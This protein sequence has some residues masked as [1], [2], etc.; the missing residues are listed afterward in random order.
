LGSIGIGLVWGWLIGNFDGQIPRP[1]FNG[2]LIS[3]IT[4]LV[5]IEI[6]ILVN[7][8]VVM[9]FIVAVIFALFIHITWR[10]SLLKRFRG[11]TSQEERDLSW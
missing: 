1:V 10:R 6:F 9:P 11:T 7:K 2:L 4:S 5:A 3:I 8:M